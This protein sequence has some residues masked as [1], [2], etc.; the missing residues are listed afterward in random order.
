MAA[1]EFLKESDPDTYNSC[2]FTMGL[3]LGE[4][5]ALCFAGCF[6]FEDGVKLAKTRGQ[7]IQFAA[8]KSNTGMA[9]VTSKINAAVEQLCIFA[10]KKSKEPVFVSMY[11]E[12]EEFVLSGQKLYR[13]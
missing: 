4:L 10:Y 5:S 7:A 3:S 11:L 13:S 1:L 8:D 2:T 12:D 9:V 6:S